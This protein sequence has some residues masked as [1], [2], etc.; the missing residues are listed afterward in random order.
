[1]KAPK[2]NSAVC[3]FAWALLSSSSR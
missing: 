3:F 1:M 2:M